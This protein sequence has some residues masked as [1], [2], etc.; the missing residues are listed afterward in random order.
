M[1]S[2]DRGWR[3]GLGLA[4]G[5]GQQGGWAQLFYRLM[6]WNKTEGSRAEEA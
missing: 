3:L 1:T 4:L 5:L 6:Q 2:W